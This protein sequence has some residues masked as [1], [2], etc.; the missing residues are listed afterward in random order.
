MD[1]YKNGFGIMCFEN[2]KKKKTYVTDLSVGYT[3]EPLVHQFICF[4]VSGLSLHDVALGCFIS[5]GDG[6]DLS[7]SMLKE[8]NNKY[9]K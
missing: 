2:V 6:R 5:Q 1:E 9:I 3:N 8:L 7:A 4:G